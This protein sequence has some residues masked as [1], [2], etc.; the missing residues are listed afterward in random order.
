MRI[1]HITPS[2]S[3]KAGGPAVSIPFLCEGLQEQGCDVTLVGGREEERVDSRVPIQ[4]FPLKRY[5]KPLRRSPAMRSWLLK[6]CCAGNV[7]ILHSHNLWGM[8]TYYPHQASQKY[9][10]L[11]VIS[12]RGTLTSYSLSTGSRF[13]SLYWTAVQKRVM[14]KCAGIHATCESELNDIRRLGIRGPVAVIPNGI[15]IQPCGYSNAQKRFL[16]LGRLHPEK[17]LECLINAW[18]L[19]KQARG[20]WV[21]RVVGPGAPEYVSRLR[22]IASMDNVAGL[23]FGDPVFGQPK[24]EEYNNAA[25]FILPSFTENFGVSVVEALSM[26]VPVI[27]NKGA[28]WEDL[29]SYNCGWWI[30]SGPESLASALLSAINTPESNRQIMGENGRALVLSKYSVSSTSRM[31]LEFYEY[32]LGK[33][34]APIFVDHIRQGVVLSR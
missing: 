9:G 28:P 4:T 24:Y 33:R 13:K 23:V 7:D 30:E 11:H 1:I 17:G 15:E 29:N 3:P 12:P 10:P 5:L 6:Q 25:Y 32:L 20:E 22:E 2:V 27:A 19:I 34:S 14:E 16:Y 8:P 21:L 26:K 18:K 31:M